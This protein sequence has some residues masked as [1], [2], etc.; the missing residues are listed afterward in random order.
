MNDE[1]ISKIIA[2]ETPIL[3]TNIIGHFIANTFP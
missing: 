1:I 3:E 2:T